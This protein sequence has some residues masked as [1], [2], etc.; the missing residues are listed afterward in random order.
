MGINVIND[1]N[2][3]I[4]DAI[5]V[6]VNLMVKEGCLL[7]NCDCKLRFYNIRFYVQGLATAIVIIT[8]ISCN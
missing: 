3:V 4:K 2:N 5:T 7:M 6:E 8:M 1:E